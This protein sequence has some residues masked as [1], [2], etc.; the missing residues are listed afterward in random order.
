M[1]Y[2]FFP[3]IEALK[4]AIKTYYA[5]M[6]FSTTA[7]NSARLDD[8]KARRLAIVREAAQRAIFYDYTLFQGQNVGET[9]TQFFSRGDIKSILK[10]GIATFAQNVTVA[11]T[12][13]GIRENVFTRDKIAWQQLFSVIQNL[14]ATSEHGQNIPFDYPSEIH[15]NENESLEI[16]LTN[17][18]ADGWLFHHGCNLIDS[19]VDLTDLSNEIDNSPLPTAQYV[20]IVYRFADGIEYAND[21]QNNKWIYS[22][23]NN[24]SA[25]L[26]GVSVADSGD[27][28]TGGLDCQLTLIDE[29]RNLEYANLIEMRGVAGCFLNPYTVYYPLPYPILLPRKDRLKIQVKN[30]SDISQTSQPT[31]LNNYLNFCGFSI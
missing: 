19:S 30:G 12:H 9:N 26:T 6:P 15:F 8:I 2:L 1:D 22:I 14:V 24:R 5:L 3:E 25:I 7:Q 27:S 16:Q 11:L 23:K 18:Q 13:Q 20:P 28:P 31:N 29:G 4:Q 10:R 21:G 17:Q